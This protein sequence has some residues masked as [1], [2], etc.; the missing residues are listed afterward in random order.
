MNYKNILLHLLL[1]GLLALILVPII[2]LFAFRFNLLDKPNHRKIHQ[3]PV[4]IIGGIV[5]SIATSISFLITLFT[6]NIQSNILAMLSGAIILLLVGI[7]DDKQNLN[8]K[9]KLLVQLLIAHFVFMQ[10]IRI[11]SLY[12]FF[13]VASININ[14]QYFLTI[15]VITGFI[16][17]INLFDGID[18]LVGSYSLLAFIIIGIISYY[19]SNNTL[20][21]LSASFIGSLLVFLRY[22]L[23]KSGKIFIGDAGTLFIGFILACS[24][25]VLI[26]ENKINSSSNISLQILFTLFLI[27]VLDSLRVYRKRIKKGN[28]PFVADRNHLHHLMLD[29]KSNH[30]QSTYLIIGF[31]I[32]IL[33]L[34]LLLQNQVSITILLIILMVLFLAIIGILNHNHQV[35]KW[36]SE[37]KQLETQKRF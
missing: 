20:V 4:P 3:T 21:V 10:G 1:S 26:K 8:A 34:S 32:A 23:K 7:I 5:I 14:V 24:A 11:E 9:I 28:S 13:G 37:I 35:K 36:T 18:G 30:I 29:F 25:L 17:A 31:I 12:G 19:Q 33:L 2:K 27:P 6:I 15:I 22:N 16:N